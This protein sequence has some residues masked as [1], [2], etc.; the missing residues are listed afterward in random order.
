M[1]IIEC[2]KDFGDIIS[3]LLLEVERDLSLPNSSLVDDTKSPKIS[4]KVRIK[5]E[6]CLDQNFMARVQ[7]KLIRHSEELVLCKSCGTGRDNIIPH[8]L[9]STT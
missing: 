7:E 5:M 8:F 9:S 6:V 1:L 2:D 3:Q 4:G